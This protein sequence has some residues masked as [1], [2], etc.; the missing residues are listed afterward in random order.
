MTI[1]EYGEVLR[2]EADLQSWDATNFV[3]NWT[4]NNGSLYIIHFLALGGSQM[5]AKVL[6]WTMK[7]S[8]GNL[9]VTGT[10]FT[11]DVVLHI[12]AGAGFTTSPPAGT[13]NE[14]FGFGAMDAAG[15]QWANVVFS[16]DGSTGSG[17]QRYQRTDQS[18]VAIDTAPSVVKEASFVSMDS[19]GFTLNFTTA[20]RSASQVYS[21][22]LA[23]VRAKR[24]AS[25]RP[26][27]PQPR[28]RSSPAYRFTRGRYC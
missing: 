15:G 18:I 27:P 12:H 10:G 16:A 8:T 6:S 3:L 1:I 25:S 26:P 7:T 19:N 4:T 23:G 2:A 17:A 13:T 20:N 28:A 9:A 11:P 21:L 24:E 14:A 22:A 5:S